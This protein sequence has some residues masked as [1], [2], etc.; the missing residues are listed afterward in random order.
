MAS[1]G[2]GFQQLMGNGWYD[3]TSGNLLGTVDPS[4]QAHNNFFASQNTGMAS[5]PQYPGAAVQSYA[6]KPMQMTGP[7]GGAAGGGNGGAVFGGTGGG[8]NGGSG[9]PG[10]MSSGSSLSMSSQNPYLSQMGD[11]LTGAMTRNWQTNVQPQIA[12]GAMAAGGYGGSRQ[13]VIE[14][15][16]ASD[17]NMGIGSALASLYGNGY[18]TSLQH[19]L[20]QQN[21]GLGYANLDRSINNDN[22][23]WQ[24]QGANFGLG[25][26]DRMQQAN[27]LGQGVGTQ[28][29]NTPM[30]YWSQFSNQANSIGQGYGTQTQQTGG[31]PLMGAI[32]GAQLGNQAANWWSSQSGNNAQ[33]YNPATAGAMAA[34]LNAN[35]YWPG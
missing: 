32:G 18:N 35:G 33:P 6:T 26:Y 3:S 21:L 28:I 11:A 16:S 9:V 5:A 30:N 1:D 27:Q 2:L 29:Q 31:N 17:L 10:G 22:L 20:G 13:G 14:S 12:S 25:V 7:S 15:N 8:G 23:G 4:K 24:M 19:D 34:S